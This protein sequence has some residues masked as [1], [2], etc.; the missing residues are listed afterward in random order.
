RADAEHELGALRQRLCLGDC[1]GRKHLAEEDDIRLHM[2]L[3]LIADRNP[4][5]VEQLLDLLEAERGTTRP[6]GAGLDRAVYLD[7]PLGSGLVVQHVDVLRDHRLE[8]IAPLELGQGSVG[9]VRLD[10][11]QAVETRAVEAPELWRIALE[12]IDVRDL[13]RI[14]VL[15]EALSGRSEVRDPARDGDPRPG[16]GDGAARLADQ[17]REANRLVR[18]YLPCHFGLRFCRKAEMP[19]LPSSERNAFAKPCFSASIPSSRSALLE[20]CLICSTA[21]GA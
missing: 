9:V 15:P 14:D 7:H 8:L 21:R 12:R 4:L 18:C 10:G 6:A 3:A 17:L 13:H 19:S 20:T 5:V 2:A 1:G 16:E 11:A